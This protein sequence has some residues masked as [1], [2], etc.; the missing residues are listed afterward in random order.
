MVKKIVSNVTV[1]VFAVILLCAAIVPFFFMILTSLKS[2]KDLY[3]IPVWA[4][5]NV[6]HFENY[7]EVLTGNFFTYLRNS[8]IVIT[9]S[10]ALILILSAMVSFS[11]VRI[12]FQGSTSILAL[13]IAGM[14]I[15]VHVTLIPVYVMSNSMG[16]I[17]HLGAL[18]GPYV[19]FNIPMSIFILSEYMKSIPKEG[20]SYLGVFFKIFLPLSRSGLITLAIFNSI[21]LW[22][23]FLFALI[24]TQSTDI[25][26]LPL[27]I[28]EFQG[29]HTA[30][31][32]MIMA[33]LTLSTLPLIIAYFIG[34][35]KLIS[36]MMSGAVK[37]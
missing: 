31:V 1:T 8:A 7:W 26:T 15:P 16:L 10:V 18:V 33:F 36:G 4:I 34:Q 3:T 19:A 9:I 2:Q 32:P 29:A 28:W 20:C 25:R 12:G 30:N 11:L 23:E 14:A 24:L 21:A 37:E 6:L 27:G 17:D 5:P 22:G 13:I 35:E